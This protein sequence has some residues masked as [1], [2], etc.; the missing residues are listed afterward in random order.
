MSGFTENRASD[1]AE[2]AGGWSDRVFTWHAC[3]AML[4]LVERI[5]QD[6]LE[7]HQSLHHRLRPEMAHLEENRRHLAWPQRA[8]R[9]Q[10]E[11][12]IAATEQQLRALLAELE[13]LGVDLLDPETGLVG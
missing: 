5:A 7:H 3:R 11:E 8:R 12:Q 6:I 2:R 10:L 4:P 13:A 1:E 9:Y